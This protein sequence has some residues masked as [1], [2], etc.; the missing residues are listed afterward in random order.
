[1]ISFSIITPVFNGGATIRDCLQSI[2]NQTFQDIEHI[3]ID[4]GS[5]D[6]TLAIINE[7]PARYRRVFSEK[8]DGIY[9]GMNKGLESASGDI[10]GILNADDMYADA[11][12][13]E[14]VFRVFE[15]PRLN[16]CYGD[17][18]YVDFYDTTKTVRFWK[19]D[20][21]DLNRF[22]WGWM[23][24]HPTFFV[25]RKMYKKYGGFNVELGTAADYELMLRLLARYKITT[26]Y[27]PKLLVKM[28]IHGV[29]NRSLVRRLAANRMD[30]KAWVVN[31][32]KPLPWT[33]IC[34]PMRKLG[35]W[36]FIK[37]YE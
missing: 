37:G 16:S 26:Q 29:S 8:D 3:I 7:F 11:Q 30:R 20:D 27:L 15:D 10:V 5:T 2:D 35:Q 19:S 22:R 1:M 4:A 23:P 31:G 33:F 17:L 28:R 25:R 13:L 36:I 9:E 34:K 21:F 6:S 14:D 12:V 24:P 18:K 32:L